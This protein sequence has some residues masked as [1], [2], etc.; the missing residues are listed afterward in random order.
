GSIP[1]SNRRHFIMKIHRI[2]FPALLRPIFRVFFCVLFL[3]AIGAMAGDSLS[4]PKAGEVYEITRSTKTSYKSAGSSGSS[5]GM[6]KLIERV[7]GLRPDG[8]ELEYDLPETATDRE[9]K[10]S[11]QFPARIFKPFDGP[12]RLLNGPE[13]EARVEN[14]LKTFKVPRAACGRTVFT[15]AAFR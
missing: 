4:A 9:R 15:W 13:L 12:P 11:W 2:F 1:R 7:T 10:R 5:Q 6:N 3:P 8:L 14:W